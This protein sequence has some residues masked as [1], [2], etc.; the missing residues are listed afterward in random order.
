MFDCANRCGRIGTRAIRPLAHIEMMAAA[1]PFL[2]GAIS[3]TI[4]MPNDATI[5]D[6]AEVL[7]RLLAADAEGDR[8]LPRRLE[9][10][11]A[12]RVAGRRGPSTMRRARPRSPPSAVLPS[13]EQVAERVVV[14][15]LRERR[16]L[17]ERR[18]GYTQKATVGGHKV[19]IRT[20]EYADGSSARSSSTCT[21]RAPP[22][23]A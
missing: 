6:V 8:A 14:E 21:R 1:Q 18:A 23:G 16:R 17:P 19:Y 10:V 3:K 4:N 15:Y 9:A 7:P 13:A 5:A 11:A 2:S 22:S 20:G 12:A